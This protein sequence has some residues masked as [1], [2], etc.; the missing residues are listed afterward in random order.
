MPQHAGTFA[1]HDRADFAQEFLRRNPAYRAHWR[2]LRTAGA[3]GARAAL[4]AR[5]GLAYPFD[6]DLP[7]RDAPAC[8]APGV[9]A[10]LV[11]LQAA[12][13]AFPGAAALPDVVPTA[14]W[15]R[16]DVHDLVLDHTGVRHRLQVVSSDP[17]APLVIL[18]APCAD[19]LRTACADAARRLLAGLSAAPPAAVMRPSALQRRR[20]TLLL[21]VLDLSL[22]GATTRAIGTGLVY[23]WLG[24]IGAQVWKTTSE[25]RRVQRLIGEARQLMDGG[26]RA[27]LH[28]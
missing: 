5:L 19:A 12:P 22:A 21:G 1:R 7:V 17:G 16:G 3:T 10:Q 18:L 24:D 2:A 15:R 26:Y 28:G 9:A 4:C 11:T 23:P 6:P 13:V 8:W 20:L 27:L 25:R 14:M